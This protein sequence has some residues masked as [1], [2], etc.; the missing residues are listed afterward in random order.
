MADTPERKPIEVKGKAALQVI[1]A[2]EGLIF[3]PQPW[4]PPAIPQPERGRTRTA[5]E[6]LKLAQQKENPD[7]ALLGR[8]DWRFQQLVST[9]FSRLTDPNSEPASDERQFVFGSKLYKVGEATPLLVEAGEHR[10]FRVELEDVRDRQ[11]MIVS[12]HLRLAHPKGGPIEANLL[13]NGIGLKRM[14]PG[15]NYDEIDFYVPAFVEQQRLLA[16]ADFLAK[17]KG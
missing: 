13:M 6:T 10:I 5:I 17:H 1:D 12:S 4:Q 7:I 15:K 16:V 3:D 8:L 14:P 11:L 2:I 9:K